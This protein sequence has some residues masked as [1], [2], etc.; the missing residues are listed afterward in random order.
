MGR[1]PV[2]GEEVREVVGKR[3]RVLETLAETAYRKPSL[4]E[5]L[6]VSRSTVDRATAELEDAGLVEYTDGTYTATTGG[7]LAL[8]V[9]EQYTRLTDGVGKAQPILDALPAEASF[10]TSLLD[11]GEIRLADPHAPEGALAT[12]VASLSQVDQ[13]RGFAPVVKSNYVS[14][15]HEHVVEDE[16]EI[17]IIVER[18]A[19]E[20]L[21]AVAASH[22]EITDFLTADSVTVLETTAELPFALWLMGEEDVPAERAGITVHDAGGIV[23]V[24]TNDRERALAWCRDRYEAERGRATRLPVDELME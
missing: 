4:V 12:A 3:T 10:D 20:S 13:L 8:T 6:D 7:T 11:G 21:A 1:E 9:Y 5:E 22:P 18:A 17:E 14:L 23:G 24:V 19:R 16:L 15:L 2:A